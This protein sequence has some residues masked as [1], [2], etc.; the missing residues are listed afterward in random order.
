MRQ[1]LRLLSVPVLSD[2][3]WAKRDEIVRQ[4]CLLD[5]QRNAALEQ[6]HFIATCVE[7][8]LSERHLRAVLAGSHERTPALAAVQAMTGSGIYCL[9]GNVGCGKTYAAHAWLLRKHK[10]ASTLA[11]MTAAEFARLSRYE[12]KFDRIAAKKR[13]VLDDLGVEYADDKGSFLADLDEL[14]DMRWRKGLPTL[15]TTNLTKQAFKARYQQRVIDRIRD[16]G[17]WVDCKHPS[18][19]GATRDCSRIK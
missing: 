19:R 12:G 15:F 5:T 18:L 7:N 14:T 4:R 2:E 9:S 6:E 8:G 3:E 11:C 1:L 13:F 17:G 10:R 16:D